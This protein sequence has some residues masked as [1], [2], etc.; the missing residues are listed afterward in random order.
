MRSLKYIKRHTMSLESISS[1]N[2]PIFKYNYVRLLI[3]NF[4]K[5]KSF[6]I[7]RRTRF[8]TS[9][10][11]KHENGGIKTDYYVMPYDIFVHVNIMSLKSKKVR[12]RTN[13]IELDRRKR[14]VNLSKRA[15]STFW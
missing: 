12:N 7:N 1:R 11:I 4:E 10:N 13:L 2:L 6:Q 3:T 15:N 14:I 5:G 8:K 9:T